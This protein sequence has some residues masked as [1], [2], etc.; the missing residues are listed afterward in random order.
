MRFFCNNEACGT[1]TFAEQV[2]DLTEPYARRS[3][4]LRGIH[5]AIASGRSHNWQSSWSP[6][7][8]KTLPGPGPVLVAS[9]T[10]RG[11]SGHAV[12]APHTA[13]TAAAGK[14]LPIDGQVTPG[15]SAMA[16]PPSVATYP[17]VPGPY[18]V[19]QPNTDRSRPSDSRSDT[20][21]LSRGGASR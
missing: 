1:R 12:D 20:G 13:A 6:E 10:Q 19:R 7:R 21:H 8:G 5:E 14:G 2:A 4:M 9:D 18:L 15:N 11:T 3:P 17:L 16:V